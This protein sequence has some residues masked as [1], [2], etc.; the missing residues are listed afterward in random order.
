MPLGISES[1]IRRAYGPIDLSYAYNKID[2]LQR[3]LAAEDRLRRQEAKKQYYTDL[4]AMN[5]EKVGV[6]ATDIPE[7]SNLYKDWSATERMLA[8]NPN[9][10]NRNPELYGQLKNKSDETYSRLMTTI[11]GSKELGKQEVIDFRE[12]A[13]PQKMDFYRENAAADYKQNV[14]NKPWSE[15]IQSGLNDITK[16]YEPRIDGS[17]F[18]GDLGQRI[19]TQATGKH[20]KLDPTFKGAP[21]ELRY[22][23]FNK[24]PM[25]G[26]TAVIV[27]DNLN[28]KLGKKADRFALQELNDAIKSG[29]YEDVKRRYNDFMT[30]GYLKY[31]DKD[32]P[33]IPLFDIKGVSPKQ[34][35]INYSTAKE[36]LSKL[37]AEGIIGKGRFGSEGAAIRYRAG[38]KTTGKEAA[39]PVEI[40]SSIV[41]KLPTQ[42]GGK[43]YIK[44]ME[45]FDSDEQ[46]VMMNIVRRNSGMRDL[47]NRDVYLQ[48]DDAGNVTVKAMNDIKDNAGYTVYR[49]GQ[50]ITKMQ[51]DGI[52]KEATK[53]F[54]KKQIMS[55]PKTTKVTTP[56][57]KMK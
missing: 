47:N 2:A 28:A 13:N 43:P 21:G 6:R 50:S 34:D 26:E 55:V 17:K 27:A 12:M 54:G 51:Q 46:D 16:Y 45:K 41:D 9:L 36:F 30:A 44:S 8:S 20:E 57:F 39:A 49:K 53:L 10:I 48:Q 19:E 29:D 35:F 40:Y 37:P 32:Q 56:P 25:L 5:K 33:V 31:F 14:I 18:Y 42:V 24:M 7:V 23:E 1:V 15:V 11:R 22:I 52:D 38:F 4:A 3:Q